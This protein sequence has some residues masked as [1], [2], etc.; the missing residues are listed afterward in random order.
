VLRDLTLD[1]KDA[2]PQP[3]ALRHTKSSSS[4]FNTREYRP[5]YLL[6][7]NRKSKDL[8]EEALPALPASGSPS[9][10]STEDEW[11]SAVES[12]G[13]DSG[14][15]DPMTEAD[16][17][18]P[19]A[20]SF[21]ANVM[22]QREIGSGSS[23]DVMAAA[24]EGEEKVLGPAFEE[25]TAKALPRPASPL[26]ASPA[27]DDT[28]MRDHASRSRDTSPSSSSSALQKVALG[29]AAGGLA[30][31]ALRNRSP[32]PAGPRYDPDDFMGGDLDDET[33]ELAAKST[34]A[35]VSP[36]AER[37]ALTRAPSSSSK[38]GKKGK[39]ESKNKSIGLTG[40]TPKELSLEERKKIEEQ[41]AADAVGDWFVDEP[42]T[43][44]KIVEEKSEPIVVE[45]KEPDP[46]LL[47][48]DSKGKGKKKAKTKPKKKGSISGPST[49]PPPTPC[50]GVLE[51]PSEEQADPLSIVSQDDDLPAS[52]HVKNEPSPS[53]YVPGSSKQYIPTFV[54]NEEDWAKNRAES[55]F[56]DEAT[57]VGEQPAGFEKN[58]KE[59]LRRKVLDTTAP[60]GDDD[61][62][63]RR[64]ELDIGERTG[65][66]VD[67][68]YTLVSPYTETRDSQ[69]FTPTKQE[70]EPETITPV[71]EEEVEAPVKGKKGKKAKKGKKGSVQVESSV[72]P[73]AP[74]PE[75]KEDIKA[76]V[77]HEILQPAFADSRSLEESQPTTSA[78]LPGDK[79]QEV[80]TELETTTP[81]PLEEKT[82]VQDTSTP[83]TLEPENIAIPVS[84]E[85]TH[86]IRETP[87][88][89]ASESSI[90]ADTK[91]E[92]DDTPAASTP[93][94]E[95]K[96]E[97]PSIVK[98]LFSA[99]G[100]GKKRSTTPEPRPATP[101]QVKESPAKAAPSTPLAQ[102]KIPSPIVKPTLMSQPKD[103][104]E[105]LALAGIDSEISQLNEPP[106]ATPLEVQETRE[107]ESVD[108][109]PQLDFGPAST[110]LK[111]NEEL[112]REIVAETL[113][114][115]VVEEPLSS[116]KSKGKKDKK[117]KRDSI[118]V[119]PEAETKLEQ[120][121]EETPR[122][123]IED[124]VPQVTVEPQGTTDQSFSL[125][126]VNQTPTT[127]DIVPPTTIEDEESKG[128][129]KKGKK[130]KKVRQ[131]SVQLDTTV[132]SGP[133]TLA[134]TVPSKTSVEV[135]QELPALPPV[136]VEEQRD[137]SLTDEVSQIDIASS[138][139]EIAPE[140]KVIIQ[141]DIVQD[142]APT[143]SKDKKKSKKGKGKKA[144]QI[145][146]EV[147]E[148]TTPIETSTPVIEEPQ[149][150]PKTSESVAP[151]PSAQEPVIA[152]VEADLPLESIQDKQVV[153]EKADDVSEPVQEVVES[154]DDFAATASNK[155]ETKNGKKGKKGKKD[156]SADVVA[157]ES[158]PA[159]IEPEVVIEEASREI[160]L[161]EEL[162]PESEQFLEPVVSESLVEEASKDET[163]LPG[164]TV[165]D[166][167]PLPAISSK[168]DKKKKGKKGK[169]VDV[170][171][172][173]TPSDTVPS[174]PIIE[175]TA[176]ELVLEKELQ[177]EQLSESISV[178]P[179]TEDLPKNET[180]SREIVE[181]LTPAVEDEPATATTSSKKD[182]KKKKGKK[183]TSTPLTELEQPAEAVSSTPNIDEATIYKQQSEVEN[184]PELVHPEALTEESVKD[185]ILPEAAIEHSEP[186]VE[187]EPARP[188]SKKDKESKEEETQSIDVGETQPSLP[189]THAPLT[190]VIEAAVLPKDSEPEQLPASIVSEPVIE[191]P[192]KDVAPPAEL[193]ENVDAVLEEEPVTS[194]SSKKK[195]KKKGKKSKSTDITGAEILQP[196]MPSEPILPE[197]MVEEPSMEVERSPEAEI[198]TEPVVSESVV[199]EPSTIVEVPEQVVD[200][201][202][203]APSS[204]KRNKKKKTKGKS[205]DVTETEPSTPVETVQPQPLSPGSTV[206]DIAPLDEELAVV[207]KLPEPTVSE[208]TVSEPIVSEPIVSEPIVSEPTVDDTA[209]TTMPLPEV[210]EESALPT[211]TKKDKK[212]KGKKGKSADVTESEPSM[213]IEAV[214]PDTPVPSEPIQA[215]HIIPEPVVEDVSAPATVVAEDDSATPTPSKKD[216]KKKGKKG[217]ASEQ[218]VA[219]QPVIPVETEP[220]PS[221]SVQE[222]LSLSAP[223]ETEPIV[224]HLIQSEP[225]LSALIDPEQ[226]PTDISTQGTSF[227]EVA[228]LA[229]TFIE[230]A[231]SSLKNDQT[232][233]DKNAKS[234]ETTNITEPI[235]IE[236]TQ[237]D[238]LV[239]EPVSEESIL[240]PNQVEPVIDDASTPATP[241]PETVDRSI[242][243]EDELAA[244]TSKKGKK[245]KGKKSKAAA[246][247]E[248]STP[249]QTQP[250]SPVMRNI[251]EDIV[252]PSMALE[253]E[254]L[255]GNVLP[256]NETQPTESE[257]A[258]DLAK[259]E[260]AVEDFAAPL[261]K[262]YQE[263]NVTGEQT[264]QDNE[265][266]SVVEPKPSKEV[267][268][269][270][271]G[272]NETVQIVESPLDIRDEVAVEKTTD[273]PAE[274]LADVVDNELVTPVSKKNKKKGKG[275]KS[276][277]ATPVSETV[278]ENIPIETIIP[279]L[280][281]PT[282]EKLDDLP[283]HATQEPALERTDDLPI[284]QARDFPVEKTD[285]PS[286][287]QAPAPTVGEEAAAPVSKNKKEGNNESVSESAQV[288]DL[289]SS[290]D[291][292]V[293]M[294]DVPAEQTQ[295]LVVEESA[296]LASKKDKKKK[297]KGK[298][299][300]T[301]LDIDTTPNTP[302]L[303]GPGTPAL[304]QEP[305]FDTLQP[306]APVSEVH[307]FAETTPLVESQLGEESQ[308]TRE[309]EPSVIDEIV[310]SVEAD[311][312]I[313][314]PEPK[315][316]DVDEVVAPPKKDKKKGKKGK[317]AA[318]QESE[319]STPLET[320]I[321]AWKELVLDDVPFETPTNE[322]ELV[323]DPLPIESPVEAKN[324]TVLENASSSVPEVAEVSQDVPVP[325]EVVAPMSTKE[326]KKAKKSKKAVVQES[327]PSTPL[328]TPIDAPKELV[329]D[330]APLDTPTNEKEEPILDLLPIESP[331]DVKKEAVVEDTP[332]SVPEVDEVSKDVPVPEEVV[333]P[334]SAKEKK[335]A[336][337][338]KKAAVQESEPSTPLETPIEAQKELVLED[339]PLDISANEKKEPILDLPS[340]ESPTEVKK[341]AVL[342]NTPVSVPEVDEVSK[343]VPVPEE[344][345]APMSAKER[346]KAKKGKKGVLVESEPSTPLET[347][348]E[349]WKELVLDDVPLETPVDEK[350]EEPVLDDVPVLAPEIAEGSKD[351]P[352]QEEA[353]VL[354]AKDRKKAKK[355]KRSST[356]ISE[357]LTPLETDVE[358]K[359]E[360]VLDDVP[361]TASSEE[362]REV[363]VNDVL[364]STPEVP[365]VSKDIPTQQDPV[366]D[367]APLSAKD[368]KKA[369]KGKKA[370]LS[371]NES[372]MQLDTPVEEKKETV[373]EDL[374]ITV[375]ET[376]EEAKNVPVQEEVVEEPT[377]VSAKDKKKSKKGKNVA[378]LESEP[379]EATESPAEGLK[380]VALDD[381]PIVASE[382]PEGTKDVQLQEDAGND[383]QEPD[384]ATIISAEDKKKAKE[385]KILSSVDIEPST[386]IETPREV[387][388]ETALDDE[389]ASK[390]EI[391]EHL[392][393]TPMEQSDETLA[394]VVPAPMSAKDKK[395]GKKGKK[396]SLVDSEPSTPIEVSTP[397]IM[398]IESLTEEP[399]EL[400]DDKQLI[401]EPEVL[402]ATPVADDS[403]PASKKEK[404][405]SKKAKKGSV[406]EDG[407]SQPATPINEAKTISFDE[408][409]SALV[410][411]ADVKD[412]ASQPLESSASDSK[413]ITVDETPPMTETPGE[414]TEQSV[415]EQEDI[416]APISKKDK[417]KGK[418]GKRGSIIEDE[419]SQPTETL[420]E[421][422]KE[423]IVEEALIPLPMTPVKDKEELV[424]L[425]EDVS[426]TPTGKKDKKKGKKG[427]K[428]P[429][430]ES[431]V[432]EPST[433]SEDIK[434]DEVFGNSAQ[435][436]QLEDKE[437]SAHIMS[438]AEG[439]LSP[440]VVAPEVQLEPLPEQVHTT[441]PSLIEE[442]SIDILE[443]PA[444]PSES[445]EPN[446]DE[447]NIPS[448]KKEKGKKGKKRQSIVEE[449]APEALTTV[450]ETDTLPDTSSTPA[451]IT[452]PLSEPQVSEEPLTF[453]H[454]DAASSQH[455]ISDSQDVEESSRE[456]VDPISATPMVESEETPAAEGSSVPTSSNKKGKKHKLASMFESAVQIASPKSSA[457][458][459]PVIKAQT[460]DE[461]PAIT[462]KDKL[463]PAFEEAIHDPAILDSNISQ[464]PVTEGTLSEVTA[465]LPAAETIQTE[466]AVDDSVGAPT[467]S[468]KK[469][470]G[471]KDKRV[472][473]F[474]DVVQDPSIPVV[475]PEPTLDDKTLGDVPSILNDELAQHLEP[476]T[477]FKELELSQPEHEIVSSLN[478]V[479]RVST[480]TIEPEEPV[481]E[482]L[483]SSSLTKKDKKKGKKVKGKQSGT[484]T[485]IS[486]IVLESRAQDIESVSAQVE[487]VQP[488]PIEEAVTERQAEGVEP[489]LSPVKEVQPTPIEE[490]ITERQAEVVE[491]I[492][493][494]VDEA[495]PTPTSTEPTE[496]ETAL[497][498][499]TKSKKKG[500]KN[501]GAASGTATP[502]QEIVLENVPIE[503]AQE[504]A[505]PSTEDS[506]PIPLQDILPEILPER[507]IP[508]NP[509]PPTEV[510]QPTPT[511]TETTLEDLGLPTS[512]KDKKKGKKGKGKQSE[513][514][515]PGSEEI[516]KVQADQVLQE[517]QPDIVLPEA[518]TDNLLAAEPHDNDHH[519]PAVP[520]SSE[521]EARSL[522]EPSMSEIGSVL[523]K[524]EIQS[525]PPEDNI[526]PVVN[527]T[528]DLE[529]PVLGEGPF[530]SAPSK[531]KGKKGKK[532][533]TATPASENVAD[534]EA[535]RVAQIQPVEQIGE[536][537]DVQPTT[538]L[539]IEQEPLTEDK[540]IPSSSK[541]SKNGK[542]RK[543]GTDTLISEV[544]PDRLAEISPPLQ[545]LDSELRGDDDL[546]PTIIK[547]TSLVQ[548]TVA[549][550]DW[551]IDM[552]KKKGKK[553][554]VQQSELATPI[555]EQVPNEQFQHLEHEVRAIDDV[556]PI[557]SSVV[558][559]E[560]RNEDDKA[561]LPSK[562]KG[563][564]NKGKQSGIATP[565][566]ETI[567]FDPPQQIKDDVR[568]IQPLQPASL[569][570]AAPEAFVEEEWS[571]KKNGEGQMSESQTPNLD[572][573]L[574]VEPAPVQGPPP[575]ID[576]A[577]VPD[578]AGS[579]AETS[580]P[581]FDE[582]V[583]LPTIEPDIAPVVVPGEN[584]DQTVAPKPNVVEKPSLS[585]KS[586]KKDKKAK[587]KSVA[588]AP[589][590]EAVLETE[591]ST[592]V[593]V[594]EP[595]SA[596]E[597]ME[598]KIA[599]TVDLAPA[600][601]AELLEH[602]LTSL[603][604]TLRAQEEQVAA[605]Q[606][607]AGPNKDQPQEII[608]ED[609]WA[610]SA[611]QKSKKGK[612]GKKGKKQSGPDDL[613][614]IPPLA[615]EEHVPEVE[616]LSDMKDEQQL[617]QNLD[618]TGEILDPHLE[619]VDTSIEPVRP[620]LTTTDVVEQ[621]LEAS[622]PQQELF[623]EYGRAEETPI[624]A[625]ADELWVP[626]T[627]K[628]SKKGKKSKE[629]KDEN[630]KSV[631]ISEEASTSGTTDLVQPLEPS[632]SIELVPEGI[633]E[634]ADI[635]DMP[636]EG[637]EDAWVAPTTKSKKDKKKGRK[638]NSTS[639]AATPTAEKEV[640]FFEESVLDTKE[641]DKRE[642]E[643]A[644][645]ET[646]Q[647]SFIHD[648]TPLPS[649]P[650][651][652]VELVETKED[653]PALSVEVE[654]ETP[655]RKLSKKDKKKVRASATSWEEPKMP[656]TEPSTIVEAQSP[657]QSLNEQPIREIIQELPREV[658]HE[659]EPEPAQIE[660]PPHKLNKK[661]KKKSKL[662]ATSWD[663]S[664]EPT[665]PVSEPSTIHQIPELAQ[666][667]LQE[668]VQE[669]LQEPVQEPLQEP[670]QEPVQEPETAAF[671]APYLA[672]QITILPE[673][674]EVSEESIE[675]ASNDLE[676][677][678]QEPA[679]VAIVEPTIE[680]APALSQLSK[681]DEN[682][683]PSS[684]NDTTMDATLPAPILENLAVVEDQN[685]TLPLAEE[686][687]VKE[688][689]PSVSRKLSKKDKKKG[690]ASASTWDEPTGPLTAPLPLA[691]AHLPLDK[692][693]PALSHLQETL[694]QQENA[695][696]ERRD[697]ITTEQA[698]V[699]DK[700]VSLPEP[701]PISEDFQESLHPIEPSSNDI[702][703]VVQEEKAGV[704]EPAQDDAVEAAPSLARKH[705]KKD[706]K[707][708]KAI[709]FDDS[710]SSLPIEGSMP[711]KGP[712]PILEER[713]QVDDFAPKLSKKDKKKKGKDTTPDLAK[714]LPVIEAP[715]LAL[716]AIEQHP[717]IDDFAPQ[718]SKKDRKK[719]KKKT[720][721]SDEWTGIEEPAPAEAI[722]D[723]VS[724]TQI[725]G[726]QSTLDD[727][728]I[729]TDSQAIVSGQIQTDILAEQT[730]GR[731]LSLEPES[732]I[733]LV[734]PEME[735]A[736]GSKKGKKPKRK[737][738][739]AAMPWDEPIEEI[740]IATPM[741]EEVQ[742]SITSFESK[743]VPQPEPTLA[744]EQE[745]DAKTKTST[746]DKRKSKTVETT[747]GETTPVTE[748]FSKETANNPVMEHPLATFPALSVEPAR[749]TP[750]PFS[751]KKK[752]KFAAI[753][754]PHTP[755]T[756][757]PPQ[758]EVF[759]KEHSV[760]TPIPESDSRSVSEPVQL[761]EA[762]PTSPILL[763]TLLSEPISQ[764]TPKIDIR[765][766]SPENNIDFAATLAA[767]LQESGFD[768]DIVLNDPAFHRSASAQRNYDVSP[769]DDV[770]A[771]RAEAS[772][773]KFGVMGRDTPSPPPASP[774]SYLVKEIERELPSTEVTAT[775][776]ENPDFDPMNV[777]SDP[778]FSERRS[779]PGVLEA[780]D[781]EELYPI[782]QKDKKH[783]GKK[784]R[785]SIPDVPI[786]TEE[787]GFDYSEATNVD[788]SE[789][790]TAIGPFTSLKTDLS[791]SDKQPF[792][793]SEIVLPQPAEEEPETSWSATPKKKGKKEKKDKKRIS[794]A[795]NDIETA[796]VVAPVI[797][798][799]IEET[800]TVEP[801]A[802]SMNKETEVENLFMPSALQEENVPIPHQEDIS[803]EDFSDRA[804]VD[805]TRSVGEQPLSI[806][807][808]VAETANDEWNEQPK[809]KNG[810]KGKGKLK[811]SSIV[812]QAVEFEPASGV[813]TP[814]EEDGVLQKDNDRGVE[815]TNQGVEA[816][817]GASLKK[818][819]KKNKKDKSESRVVM[820]AVG[821]AALGAMATANDATLESTHDKRDADTENTRGLL[822]TS[823]EQHG[824]LGAAIEID[825]YPFP[826]MP[827]PIEPQIA[828]NEAIIRREEE[829]DLV[830]E[831][832]VPLKKKEKKER[833][834]KRNVETL[835]IS[836]SREMEETR[837]QK[838]L[839]GSEFREEMLTSDLTKDV[840]AD[841]AIH[842]SAA[843]I[844]ARQ[845][846][847]E[848]Q[849]GPSSSTD[850]APVAPKSEKV[851]SPDKSPE[852]FAGVEHL[853]R[854][855]HPISTPDA[856][857]YEKRVHMSEPIEQVPTVQ[858]EPATMSRNAVPETTERSLLD[859][860]PAPP[861]ARGYS[862]VAE[863]TWSFGGIRD[864]AVHVADP[865]ELSTT[866]HFQTNTRDSG[867]HDEEYSADV[868]QAA[869][870]PAGELHEKKKRR[871]KEP[872][873]RVVQSDQAFEEHH[874]VQTR[875]QSPSL[876]LNPS[877]AGISSPSAIASTTKERSS[878]LLDSSPSTRVHE[879]PS[880]SKQVLAPIVAAA[881]IGATVQH[882]KD[883]E[884]EPRHAE[885]RHSKSRKDRSEPPTSTSES[886]ELGSSLGQ[887]GQSEP[888]QSIFGDPSKR[889]D[890][891][892]PISTP[893]S[894]QIQTPR[895][896]LD[897][898]KEASPDDSPL[899]KKSRHI[900]DV[901]TPD[902]RSLKTARR[903]ASSPQ[904]PPELAHLSRPKT[905][906]PS[907][908]RPVAPSVD[909]SGGETPSKG[910]ER[911]GG[912]ESV[913]R[914]MT[915][916]PARRFP[917][918]QRPQT[919]LTDPIKQRM[920]EERSSSVMST[921]STTRHKTPDHLRPLSSA[922]N[923]PSSPSLRRV[924]RSISGDLRAA[925]RLGEVNAPGAKSAHPNLAGI[926][927]AAGAT[928]A[929]IA[930]IASSSKYDPV[931]DKGKGRADMPDVYVS[932]LY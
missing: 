245:K 650:Q 159:A 894:K 345:V 611:P 138:E 484:A 677:P 628:A 888:H 9:L 285:E 878:Q 24:L 76:E 576:T 748:M 232:E 622:I 166:E 857:P 527:S 640:P 831:W 810:K 343:D 301:A 728:V 386:F 687:A 186:A 656:I 461:S 798:T 65:T 224:P 339:V 12:V 849:V 625:D 542:G 598:E 422:P 421:E 77:E 638:S 809:T 512:K 534:Q 318:L 631:D 132:E 201:D 637:P 816:D 7:R 594:L 839:D 334:M 90:L 499:L 846:S 367:A 893:S 574:T 174:T 896:Q 216:K 691:D 126:E 124:V 336:K 395:K 874:D 153:V 544:V 208:P 543:S 794:L 262:E 880:I 464:T 709:T 388:K 901:G 866:P 250:S 214:Q 27:F 862:P 202:V 680:E 403:A 283:A 55:V 582:P 526:Q 516:E 133:S 392:S 170:A 639:V 769:D 427:K 588:F 521:Q 70:V 734:K 684:R 46:N 654:V 347:P 601:S 731:N 823:S 482:E 835:P 140:A 672:E 17:I 68:M 682:D 497:P 52:T 573:S 700:E 167:P 223:V 420:V 493:P 539:S 169:S 34:P 348:I 732:D 651:D 716:E 390:P 378:L 404:K 149:I 15:D 253:S 171:D 411:P 120:E 142:S 505:L 661:D 462:M 106:L 480:A 178:Q 257:T 760:S 603:T 529:G 295:E 156:K 604:P 679:P 111:S 128:T 195:E 908:R 744:P 870:E 419:P 8:E 882:S 270:I 277:T 479:E 35:P 374:P 660:T 864:S 733:A 784:K 791:T 616:G 101:P 776:F 370:S 817:E 266:V 571:S 670:V 752:H 220:G 807:P 502:T 61:L 365:E 19:K 920:A 904:P 254:P 276:G 384:V 333:A 194:S 549:E 401:A 886:K 460:V 342:E 657:M 26:A 179:L 441:E 399:M 382:L 547:D 64:A 83:S 189:S 875:S 782:S 219:E 113:T 840:V 719:G 675:S 268:P 504:P 852:L 11:Q 591:V 165:D 144:A 565:T 548:E 312:S 863:P 457:Q 477:P 924:E 758:S 280:D 671:E 704:S 712:E 86:D 903:F 511:S 290:V 819:G 349:A 647:S 21:P 643:R 615:S 96:A 838:T 361:V 813:M 372:P 284:E 255:P 146:P 841:G 681:Q 319:P 494:P 105:P 859:V 468:K 902:H 799:P 431:E 271:E 104:S 4:E 204:S 22:D 612:K 10:A 931:R 828:S 430:L 688:E 33:L 481:I 540:L 871:S 559:Q 30:A 518:Q 357:P 409:L 157:N 808:A 506:Q 95:P 775:T 273:L 307:D 305:I 585:R 215:E 103:L 235:E 525:S 16:Q 803:S 364:V 884:V 851:S 141:D 87:V 358:E 564:K 172:L 115:P 366:V 632:V 699:Y 325:E 234:I 855:E 116:K 246:E 470:K 145:E 79:A 800:L 323:L 152:N 743:P 815:S 99:F 721:V 326:K 853:K 296:V 428:G 868:A 747:Y 627:K 741:E 206:K 757:L 592:E 429:V 659:P 209:T 860:S 872:R 424:A 572:I 446:A 23:R 136:D 198:P 826:S 667:S 207:E 767:G 196:P 763:P 151:L 768:S 473:T 417:K 845:P 586:S 455:P 796:A 205:I 489:V 854:R 686:A 919:P 531:K 693:Q 298:G 910:S 108:K 708:V 912:I 804:L 491:S 440:N 150:E 114:E 703:D 600:P 267:E 483:A 698:H 593:N 777:L 346:K 229:T 237:P 436:R 596:L 570:P 515:V 303:E 770:A 469:K 438:P 443:P 711:S 316:E 107:V 492:L 134:E 210:V 528:L 607:H 161:Q 352:V 717:P 620:T 135:G 18:T 231:P 847:M 88:P 322:K 226:L 437:D 282:V 354:S 147:A 830:D 258:P 895:G 467:P 456:I 754:E 82:D 78:E 503:V 218:V 738:K 694:Q 400:V 379:S 485:P 618:D 649:T 286:I 434:I 587:R 359:K 925:S 360:L 774:K 533:G 260:I 787:R 742:E 664:H 42:V 923:R 797:E 584:M 665:T 402:E 256:S 832:A 454:G 514:T 84:P 668:S 439:N 131:E 513:T 597:S 313:P 294:G 1:L 707:K 80:A 391:L 705:S 240:E 556:E 765:S 227:H 242:P 812:E 538:T 824:P 523:A 792:E 773:S 49:S 387:L 324:E 213:P 552:S 109:M 415:P 376:S 45:E 69:F 795:N 338:G 636:K 93:A 351:V 221:E 425:E 599:P 148:P 182:K 299:N 737:S 13:L 472:S 217:K 432:S 644:S 658:V 241:L 753:F 676:V 848:Q 406:L 287:E 123:N 486:E 778:L 278:P 243:V 522:D 726:E 58:A 695:V 566:A 909:A 801:P 188:S 381:L 304:E 94:P 291:D 510:A 110:T 783:K 891:P 100:W 856:Q 897:S 121:V 233:E 2:S 162:M 735:P 889:T 541:K 92:I 710:E 98:S 755:E 36:P 727:P 508:G 239:P 91:H 696:A 263:K 6:E 371:I 117:G 575:T 702:Q 251:D 829:T 756:I 228:E 802:V 673:F 865:P 81:L 706:K 674:L 537:D 722:T 356:L 501:K 685:T 418:K 164:S 729:E 102:E 892:V 54:D 836:G 905:P 560:P 562:K 407:S 609:D 328:E 168:K 805:K 911:H 56:T 629:S 176:K 423:S 261:S 59:E 405:R 332:V 490:A 373:I 790:K 759:E 653:L 38:G 412:E 465:D 310:P 751:V 488:T 89:S 321:E 906:T 605:F 914:S 723:N 519:S 335:K 275:K 746:M 500:K 546:Q 327:E 471:K 43:E 274:K 720:A 32:S 635:N 329:L 71:I 474:E 821:A 244:P 380:Q 646:L 918:E 39:K 122:A 247:S 306:A 915:L 62:N 850:W 881:A 745:W 259:E 689:R 309:V 190:P 368:K 173:Q 844:P 230:D 225:V 608:Q 350:E 730:I 652:Q 452:E 589:D 160:P 683:K 377:P 626:L 532:S 51:T 66:Q 5:L 191:E 822:P 212:K 524:P 143:S 238:V 507:D 561:A 861:T 498:T 736:F 642:P 308:I 811:R 74:L 155:D 487:E 63:V 550:D 396:A 583:G 199:E 40:E 818:K 476:A 926:T 579:I 623:I 713:T 879:S 447:W 314:A 898:I 788:L 569:L 590:D 869:S 451:T 858:H 907:S 337:K 789:E 184:L 193:L 53:S 394:A 14:V 137:L 621:P 331:M 289:E 389:L 269:E 921:R 408:P 48:R 293:K 410:T 416:I 517:V 814:F 47:R 129:T 130:G 426:K 630:S 772:K 929:V 163:L 448:I 72:I 75:T 67:D 827:T 41:D 692:Q 292:I 459:S 876:P 25:T 580:Q 180:L 3:R 183:G 85:N 899:H 495:Q 315:Q 119:L 577:S 112:R 50:E 272:A 648:E 568:A 535:E 606:I 20:F 158:A 536:A 344:V 873:R 302:T 154:V 200:E 127:A 330:D 739:T 887:I 279:E 139:K 413:A 453:L 60:V 341:E 458:V 118:P 867:Y 397:T 634:T 558:Q 834:S 530:P 317:K 551:A 761:H 37:P 833:K 766:N 249:A 369:K 252:V 614:P 181:P 554:K 281:T 264:V 697:V 57:L 917:P 445:R 669:P 355:A 175:E 779:S 177:P 311:S 509:L 678:S 842:V 125:P 602:E 641:V 297:K 900:S 288:V 825:E 44:K 771:A 764:P 837:Q 877:V 932:R 930:G 363:V 353:V 555:S 928:A 211:S 655:S 613:D 520:T 624:D 398:P 320:P 463:P 362:K 265:L 557:I 567:T 762:K 553:G 97:E 444:T 820:A 545:T 433:P 890:K 563:K 442:K 578:I 927:L 785:A 475:L 197:P 300:A 793:P 663:G 714:P 248:P 496:E 781:P 185:D 633:Q 393:M 617:E 383:T 724:P 203:P 701:T 718:S 916:S 385:E 885:R 806:I 786:E 340:T 192:S 666:E 619:T 843:A 449:P 780:A 690:K 450:P 883:V 236:S 715:M 375:P 645:I 662:N 435:V 581:T 73:E 187:D 478:D 595:P 610:S 913:D 29:A 922:S 749:R 740:Q 222:E 28:K 725:E 31:L 466:E 414:V 750:S